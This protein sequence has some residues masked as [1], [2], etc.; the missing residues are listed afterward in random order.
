MFILA[1]YLVLF[2]VIIDSFISI[3][4]CLSGDLSRGLYWFSAGLISFSTLLIK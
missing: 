3:A 2:L 1:N 4:Y